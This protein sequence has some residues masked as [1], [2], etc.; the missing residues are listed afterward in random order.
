[1]K[2]ILVLLATLAAFD[3]SALPIGGGPALVPF[4]L[5]RKYEVTLASGG[6]AVSYSENY[7]QNGPIG[8]LAM[9]LKTVPMQIG[10]TLNGIIAAKAAE[11]GGIFM[12]GSLSGNPTVQIAP[13]VDGT[14]L[15]SLSG[16][17]YRTAVK[18]KIEVL[19][20]TIFSCTANLQVDNVSIVAQ[21]GSVD[22]LIRDDSVGFN[23]QPSVDTNCN[24]FLSWLLPGIGSYL[25]NRVENLADHALLDGVKSAMNTIKDTLLL[26]PDQNFLRGLNALVPQDKTI[27]L[28][29]G[30]VLPIGQYVHDNVAYL[31]SKSTF[32]M[33]ISRGLAGLPRRFGAGGEITEDTADV[34]YLSL[35]SPVLSFDLLLQEKSKTYWEE[36]CG[37]SGYGNTMTCL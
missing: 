12:G 13:R 10:N 16:V 34:L 8:Q 14:A 25:T 30:S 37:G 29:N 5:E 22:G 17:S 9:Q 31:A 26:S 3:A 7:Y 2:R 36:T 21:Y 11:S 19:G 4:E 20:I 24:S 6:Y 1:M 27:A 35:A 23:G 28:P 33:Q 32:T 15:M 18:K